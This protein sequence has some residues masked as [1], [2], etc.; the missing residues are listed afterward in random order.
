MVDYCGRALIS[1]F[2]GFFA[3]V[4]GVVAFGGGL[5]AGLSLV[6]CL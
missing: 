3:G 1:V 6:A 2:Q 5:S 4:G